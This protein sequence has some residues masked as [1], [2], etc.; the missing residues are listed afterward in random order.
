[1]AC[2]TKCVKLEHIL[3]DMDIQEIFGKYKLKSGE[4]KSVNYNG[5][6]ISV[7]K[8]DTGWW[9]NSFHSET[10]EPEKG[11]YYQTGTSDSL[12]LSA[13]L[14]SKPLVFKGNGLI[15]MPGQTIS[16]YIKISLAVHVYHTK[17]VDKNKITEIIHTRLSDTWF[18]EPVGGEAA[19]SIGSEFSLS[20]DET[21]PT[22][23][24]SICP[25][26]VINNSEKPLELERLIIR[27]E[28]LSL[29]QIENKILTSLVKLNYKGK[30]ALSTASYG[31]TRNLHGDKPQI[32]FNS[33]SKNTDGPLKINFHF[34][35]NIY[36]NI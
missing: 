22:I 31:T 15:V 8:E 11:K 21:E 18:G 29:Y 7:I 32:I 34:I 28:N 27:T 1:M 3:R 20:F 2:K 5:L 10:T 23:S 33:L 36:K 6:T 25:I 16:F 35:R 24:E 19:F 4:T 13:A 14:P 30:D 26:S 17:K 12:I 9:I